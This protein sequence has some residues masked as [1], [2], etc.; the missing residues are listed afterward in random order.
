MVNLERIC[1]DFGR[2]TSDN[3][4]PG[5][6]SMVNSGNEESCS[7]WGSINSQLAKDLQ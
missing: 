1:D 4:D 6:Q 7:R 3:V 5:G 2:I